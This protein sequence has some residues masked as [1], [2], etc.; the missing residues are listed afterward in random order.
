[1]SE[2][3]HGLENLIAWHGRYRAATS[4]LSVRERAARW[5]DGD[6]TGLSSIAVWKTMMGQPSNGDH[7]CDPS[8][9]GRILRL[10]ALIPE[11]S[12]RIG[13]MASASREWSAIVGRWDEIVSS[14]E[15]ETGLFGEH[16]NRAP[17]TYR[18][19]RDV[20]ERTRTT[21]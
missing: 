19:L 20:L 4:H 1:M 18:L 17:H 5:R 15:K 14:L 2:I 11:W 13:E 21:S 10:L 6:D 8:D 9:L 12:L 3:P 16:G 7:P